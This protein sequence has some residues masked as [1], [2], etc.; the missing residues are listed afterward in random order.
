MKKALLI[1]IT[2]LPLLFFGQQPEKQKG[3]FYVGW[4][5][6]RDW[7]SKSNIYLQNNNPQIINGVSYTYDFT[8]YNAKAKD[9]PQFDR[10]KDVA[11]ITIPQFGFRVGYFL[12]NTPIG[13]LN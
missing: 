5:Y 7:Y 3:I 11:N 6:N 9:R 10:I 2:G 4:G 13:G 1:I 12:L 8:V